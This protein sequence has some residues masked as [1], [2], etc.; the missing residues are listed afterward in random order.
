MGKNTLLLNLS[1]TLFNNKSPM[2]MSSYRIIFL[3]ET[4]SCFVIVLVNSSKIR[5][6]GRLSPTYECSNTALS[7]AKSLTS[8]CEP[9]EISFHLPTPDDPR[10]EEI[11]PSQVLL[12][13]CSGGC[14]QGKAYKC[15]PEPGGRSSKTFEVVYNR[16]NSNGQLEMLCSKITLETHTAC[17]CR[18]NSI[19]S[20]Q[21]I[22]QYLL[23]QIPDTTK[24][25]SQKLQF[26]KHK[27]EHQKKSS[28]PNPGPSLT[29]KGLDW[30]DSIDTHNF[31]ETLPSLPDENHVRQEI[32]DNEN[33]M[34]RD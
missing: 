30:L 34:G 27:V 3:F 7:D 9:R 12:P 15:I 24:V 33:E 22:N 21:N 25:K 16:R 8:M 26:S 11:I 14:L 32:I 19:H 13:R 20:K 28:I 18:T 1:T 31:Q 10:I 23:V 4:I 6:Q 17:S 29:L 2:E 5:A